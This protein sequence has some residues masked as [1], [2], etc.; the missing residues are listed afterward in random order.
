MSG[1]TGSGPATAA[2]A[3]EKDENVFVS[4][5]VVGGGCSPRGT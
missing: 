4:M 5:G 3:A 2:Q 1:G